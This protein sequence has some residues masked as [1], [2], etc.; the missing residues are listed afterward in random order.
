MHSTNRVFRF[1]FSNFDFRF[2]VSDLEN[3]QVAIVGVNRRSRID[4]L[5]FCPNFGHASKQC[6]SV[7]GDH[8]GIE[9]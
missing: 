4:V 9:R 3:I 1:V 7:T 6:A 5:S 2:V 8:R